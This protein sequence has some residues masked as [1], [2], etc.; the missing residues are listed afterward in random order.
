MKLKRT[1]ASMLTVIVSLVFSTVVAF[2]GTTTDID[3]DHVSDINQ[4]NDPVVTGDCMILDNSDSW[5]VIL[6][7]KGDFRGSTLLSGN[8][9][10]KASNFNLGVVSGTQWTESK[11]SA[12]LV[13]GTDQ[14]TG[15]AMFPEV[16]PWTG[17]AF[18]GYGT[19]VEKMQ[20][21]ILTPIRE[22]G[23]CDEYDAIVK[24]LKE[25]GPSSTNPPSEE[26]IQEKLDSGEYFPFFVSFRPVMLYYRDG[27]MCNGSGVAAAGRN[28]DYN[29]REEHH[30]MYENTKRGNWVNMVGRL[31]N[32]SYADSYAPGD[33]GQPH[34]WKA[35]QKINLWGH[36]DP[37]FDVNYSLY[38]FNPTGA[39]G[40]LPEIPPPPPP[41]QFPPL[42]IEP[43]ELL[44]GITTNWVTPT[45]INGNSLATGMK[46]ISIQEFNETYGSGR[47]HQSP[48][49]NGTCTA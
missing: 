20:K 40:D 18:D 8:M 27:M 28:W 29:N 10:L 5:E 39:K 13:V 36:P 46:E 1:I 37:L 49:A 17:N 35:P 47:V 9:T 44:A 42:Y 12:P 48:V 11:K 6:Y 16:P 45:P 34:T 7:Y 19:Q 43:Y 31:S 41:G 15:T 3:S 2:A 23:G 14:A 30:T 26:E 33:Y 22:R 25:C 38:F 24:M 4:G 32:A 21:Q